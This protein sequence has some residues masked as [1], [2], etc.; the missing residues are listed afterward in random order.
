MRTAQDLSLTG[1]GGVASIA[2][3][4]HC[5][6]PAACVQ[7]PAP[8]LVSKAEDAAESI[9]SDLRPALMSFQDEYQGQ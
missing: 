3:E 8:L 6:R 7:A 1:G 5:A 2:G 4:A 9:K